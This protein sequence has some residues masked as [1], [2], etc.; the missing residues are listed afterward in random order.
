MPFLFLSQKKSPV[1]KML[2]SLFFIFGFLDLNLSIF[3]LIYILSIINVFFCLQHKPKF[4][5]RSG[6]DI[7]KKWS[8]NIHLTF[9]CW[10]GNPLK[11][12]SRPLYLPWHL[13]SRI[14]FVQRWFLGS[15]SLANLKPQLKQSLSWISFC[16]LS[17]DVIL[18]SLGQPKIPHSLI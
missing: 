10:L 9:L 12:H 2:T 1:L 15:L 6:A 7:E 17:S 3:L 16:L 4:T 13:S 11:L 8:V 14:F 18:R 5:W